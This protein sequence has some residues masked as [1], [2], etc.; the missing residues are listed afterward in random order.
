MANLA[1]R[2][3][4]NIPGDFFVDSTAHLER[5]IEWMKTR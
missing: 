4:E 1:F 2:L 5:C 3:A